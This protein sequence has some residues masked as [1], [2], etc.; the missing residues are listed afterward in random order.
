MRH[1]KKAL[2]C[3]LT[4]F[5]AVCVSVGVVGCNKNGGGD[6]HE[7]SFKSAW[8]HD[9]T[10][11]WHEAD[12]GHTDL[13]SGL[14][15]HNY[16]NDNVC[17]DC[18]YEKPEDGTTP[19]THSF[20]Q[21]WTYD[22]TNHW[23][24]AECEHTE[25]TKGLAA[26]N[27]GNDNECDD[28]GY[29]KPEDGA[30]PHTHQFKQTWE[31][32]D[33]Y[34]WH[35]AECEHKNLTE[36]LAE[37]D[38]GTGGNECVD[39]GY[40]LPT[41]HVHELSNELVYDNTYHWY[42]ALCSH[43]VKGNLD[44]HILND[45]LKCEDCDYKYT[46]TQDE[47]DAYD[48]YKK[49][50]AFLGEEELSFGAWKNML[51]EQGVSE[52]IVQDNGDVLAY[53]GDDDDT[54]AMLYIS[55]RKL[56]LT[57]SFTTGEINSD[58]WYKL[59][60][61]F[62]G[63]EVVLGVAKT[64]AEGKLEFTFLPVFGYSSDETVYSIS[65]AVVED[66][67]EA[68]QASFVALN[69]ARIP[70]YGGSD[71]FTTRPGYDGSPYV[72]TVDGEAEITV[73][74]SYESKL[75]VG[76][77]VVSTISAY[78]D[79]MSD[80]PEGWY[81]L[82][83]RSTSSLGNNHYVQTRIG[84]NTS[85]LNKY[86]LFAGT[87]TYTASIAI[88]LPEGTNNLYFGSNISGATVSLKVPDEQ[89]TGLGTYSAPRK[90]LNCEKFTYTIAESVAP[91]Y[92]NIVGAAYGNKQEPNYG[93][94]TFINGEAVSTLG[95]RAQNLTKYVEIYGVIEIKE[96]DS[97]ISFVYDCTDSSTYHARFVI[98]KFEPLN[99]ADLEESNSFTV[100][101]N[102]AKGTEF[103]Y[104]FTVPSNVPEGSQF[105]LSNTGTSGYNAGQWM[106]LSVSKPWAVKG[107][108]SATKREFIFTASAGET[109]IIKAVAGMALSGQVTTNISV[110]LDITLPAPV[111]SLNDGTISWEAVPGVT[112]Y[113][114]YSGTKAS[115][116]TLVATV[117]E[118]TSYTIDMESPAASAMYY[119][120]TSFDNTENSKLTESAKSNSV[121]YPVALA[122]PKA[123]LYANVVM[124]EPVMGAT[125]YYV[126]AASSNSGM[127]DPIAKLSA[128]QLHYVVD[129]E[130]VQAGWFI[131][132]SAVNES[133]LAY[134]A[135]S[136]KSSSML[137]KGA[138]DT[139]TTTLTDNIISWDAVPYARGYRVSVTGTIYN[140]ADGT[141]AT[142]QEVTYD[143]GNDV[144]SFTITNLKTGSYTVKV[145][146]LSGSKYYTDSSYSSPKYYYETEVYA[147]P[148]LKIEDREGTD[149]LTW[150][151]IPHA[152]R[153]EVYIN[154]NR[155]AETNTE[156]NL[157]STAYYKYYIVGENIITV[158][159]YS[160]YVTESSVFPSGEVSTIKYTVQAK[161]LATPVLSYNADTKQL[162]WEVIPNATKY[163]IYRNGDS[164]YTI[165]SATTVMYTLNDSSWDAGTYEFSIVAIN[166]NN[167]EIYP[168]SDSSNTIQYKVEPS[169][170]ETPVT[171]IT[172][173]SNYRRI[174]WSKITNATGYN[175]YV[176]GVKV[177]S[178]TST[179]NFYYN[180]TDANLKALSDTEGA[181]LAELSVTVEAYNTTYPNK[182]LTSDRSTPIS[183]TPVKFGA[184]VLTLDEN[185]SKLTWAKVTV[186]DYNT[187]IY[188]SRYYIYVNGTQITT[189]SGTS[190]KATLDWTWVDA[191]I[192]AYEVVANAEGKYVV[193][194]TAA[195]STAGITYTTSDA[196]TYTFTPAKHAAPVIKLNDAGTAVTWDAIP[197]AN[198]YTVY[199]NGTQVATTTTASWTWADSAITEDIKPTESGE[200]VVTVT[201][202]STTTS[203]IYLESEKSN[204]LKIK[205]EE[206]L[207][208]PVVSVNETKTGVTWVAIKGAATYT[209]YVNDT[210]V[211]S[212]ATTSWTWDDTV[213]GEIAP[214]TA[215]G[216][217]NYYEIT[218]KAV[219]LATTSKIYVEGDKSTAVELIPVQISAPTV[220][221]DEDGIS[222]N[223]EAIANAS[224]Y[225][226]FV[227]EEEVA[228]VTTTSWTFTDAAV[229]E[230]A[231]K[232]EEGSSY[233]EITVKAINTTMAKLFPD[234]EASTAVK[235]TVQTLAA[236]TLTKTEDKYEI[237]WEAIA[238]A[239]AYIIYVEGKEVATVTALKWEWS[240]D[241][242]F[243]DVTFNAEGYNV[244]VV[245]I[246][247]TQGKLFTNSAASTAQKFEVKRL[248]KPLNVKMSES[249]TNRVE[250]EKVEGATLYYIYFDGKYIENTSYTSYNFT[251][252]N[253]G[254][255]L[256]GTHKVTVTAVISGKGLLTESEMSNEA[257]FDVGEAKEAK[258][259][260][261]FFANN[262][263]G[264]DW[265]KEVK[266]GLFEAD[267]PSVQVGETVTIVRSS[268]T[269][270]NG[271]ASVTARNDKHY[272]WK[273]VS[274]MPEGWEID[275]G[276]YEYAIWKETSYSDATGNYVSFYPK[277]IVA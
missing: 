69:T 3:L 25:L 240:N 231:A 148:E 98:S 31:H 99:I 2:L 44:K 41:G 37:H 56:T 77:N 80:I 15:A 122:T 118:G 24:E 71:Y 70:G 254:T 149:Y 188:S 277:K 30:T 209:V 227:N 262:A 11:H 206:K 241:L 187:D 180:L 253:L 212:V 159:A 239:T 199:I 139:P 217:A 82:T 8:K 119:S 10:N 151:A 46:P 138:I 5:C 179:L 84:L 109:L 160:S 110:K 167:A 196:A 168:N 269:S 106:A 13:T 251:V 55:E 103:I 90:D 133:N 23:H 40:T 121:G 60:A 170:L 198:S 36:G 208:T 132:V 120:V 67:K 74:F 26:H 17:D 177:G 123:T 38:Y 79:L 150:N 244:T 259:T 126:Y 9:E 131:A 65:L 164:Y 230:I 100:K 252:F 85:D 165:S 263:S 141:T 137:F 89:F 245:A 228:T 95:V 243:K 116:T 181:N 48:L 59:T 249:T 125:G 266:F 210:E 247:T 215:E 135:V 50:V 166:T 130:K 22:E 68:D 178:S 57:S 47:L 200:Y 4:F 237:T 189:V 225:I 83:V 220:T 218:V 238:N 174:S 176:N 92:Y 142:Y 235:F 204:E 102:T 113:K 175:I 62:A 34:H 153:Y 256:P 216:K 91:G 214:K 190:S 274:E 128:D 147:A 183:L 182:Y 72:C 255:L 6:G 194:V 223:W 88:Y 52:V 213:V 20:K 195:H 236:P 261:R 161:K 201:A 134:T 63:N 202:Y 61:E 154:G 108:P 146:T 193:T 219:P 64:D 224:V 268:S 28:C 205:A 271:Y 104:K 94:T 234:S 136:S 115:Q 275:N 42:P 272:I 207:G 171:S 127:T 242:N 16:G 107:N 111:I 75:G 222:V 144:L 87:G 221:K 21:T 124:W 114:V 246:N 192:T 58:I 248:E 97:T 191:T 140:S 169:Q 233:Y 143:L 14:A 158:S 211:A 197:T 51:T 265:S 43:N 264:W 172:I 53:F 19:H 129:E 226:V 78:M 12:C 7:H 81:I 185:G 152:N 229:G 258:Y 267:N 260:V 162:S 73:D 93:I 117:T 35:E 270:G 155:S 186:S 27:Y 276:D 156:I 45:E 257:E 66:L 173:S 18:G 96:G 145:M 203:L 54:G 29:K 157:S 163:I 112:A 250:W 76:I 86:S 33:T 105:I 184:P 232:T 273:V 1:F 101:S 32:D 39:C 49:Y